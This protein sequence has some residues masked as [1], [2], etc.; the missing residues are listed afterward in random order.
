M[1]AKLAFHDAELFITLKFPGFYRVSI[2][3][4]CCDP[5]LD[6]YPAKNRTPGTGNFQ[7]MKPRHLYVGADSELF[8]Y[9]HMHVYV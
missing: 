7:G 8:T 5:N 4:E 1:E 9:V 3:S 6:P 2:P